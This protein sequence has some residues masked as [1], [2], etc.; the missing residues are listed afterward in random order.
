MGAHEGAE[1]IEGAGVEAR[2]VGVA[3]DAMAVEGDEGVDRG[4]WGGLLRC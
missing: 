1:E 4:G 2:V 3:G